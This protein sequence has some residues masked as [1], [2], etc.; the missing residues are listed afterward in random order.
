MSVLAVRNLVVAYGKL[1]ALQH[2]TLQV[3]EHNLREA[4]MRPRP[5]QKPRPPILIGGYVDA[6]LKRVATSGDGWLTYFYTPE[7]YRR[8][9]DKILGFAREAGRDP[10]TL[11]G[12]NQLAI[13]VGR[14]R[15]AL[16][17]FEAGLAMERRIFAGRDN[18]ELAVTLGRT[19]GC[20]TVLGQSARALPL[21]E[22][23][24]AM[25]RRLYGTADHPDLALDLASLGSCLC[26]LGRVSEGVLQCEASLAMLRRIHGGE[27]ET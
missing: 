23:A 26:A 4:V 8:G 17:Q 22:E 24:V 6:V 21:F 10:Q 12:T 5:F 14:S 7:S 11:S 3:D 9:W 19:A 27:G 25:Y 1:R 16:P 20:L 13:Y 18:D 2:V 15:E